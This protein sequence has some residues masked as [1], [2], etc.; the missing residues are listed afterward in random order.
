MK[1]RL[2][3]SLI[4]GAL[5][6]VVC[7]LGASIRSGDTSSQELFLLALWYNRVV[8]GLSIGLA[9]NW[10]LVPGKTNPYLRGTVLGLLVS[11]A[12]YLSTG[13]RDPVSFVAGIV[14]GLIIDAVATRFGDPNGTT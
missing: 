5:L 11:L 3:L 4:S 2:L 13:L 10:Q 6:G 12:F 7:I 1:R 8:M 9:A 14:Y